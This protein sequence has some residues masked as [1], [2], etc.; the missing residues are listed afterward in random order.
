MVNHQE[1]NKNTLLNAK[2]LRHNMTKE[3]V[4]LWNALKNKQLMGLKFR[5]QVPIGNY[6]VDFFC[7]DKN[8]II[9]LDGGQ[10]NEIQNIEYDKT[11]TDYLNKQGYRVLRFWN[12][13]V[14]NNFTGVIE[15]IIQEVSE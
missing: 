1:Y 10:H 8:L 14:W 11:R 7:F 12:D 5:R 9:E 13:D 15:K 2:N 3:E 6:V 4:K